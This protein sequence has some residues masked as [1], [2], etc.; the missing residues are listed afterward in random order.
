MQ[1]GAGSNSSSNSSSSGGGDGELLAA[2]K[3][4]FDGGGVT[5]SSNYLVPVLLF[6]ALAPLMQA[7]AYRCPDAKLTALAQARSVVR[8]LS[9]QLLQLWRP[10]AASGAAGSGGAS[11]GA[12]GGSRQAGGS[13]TQ[14]TQQPGTFPALMLAAQDRETGQPLSDEVVSSSTALRVWRAVANVTAAMRVPGMHT[15]LRVCLRTPRRACVC[16]C[17]PVFACVCVCVCMCVCMC[18]CM[19]VCVCVCARRAAGGRTAQYVCGRCV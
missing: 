5:N 1:P 9:L 6:P 13:K 19:C 7:A 12:G 15:V 8:R 2:I 4:V 10:A 18:M 16:M 14:Q 17:L 11:N 3:A